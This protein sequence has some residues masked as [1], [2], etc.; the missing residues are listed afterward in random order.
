MCK[1]DRTSLATRTSSEV[2]LGRVRVYGGLNLVPLVVVAVVKAP[3]VL[4]RQFRVH[5]GSDLAADEPC[6]DIGSDI[7]RVFGLFV[8]DKIEH[9]APNGVFS[10]WTRIELMCGLGGVLR[11]R[12]SACRSAWFDPRRFLVV[13]RILRR[14]SSSTT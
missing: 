7:L 14:S 13:S 2:Q 10:V 3:W 1:L 8:W 4:Q 6:V 12:V 9:A 5:M 11:A